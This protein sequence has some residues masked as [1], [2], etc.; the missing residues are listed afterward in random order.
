MTA[1]AAHPGYGHTAIGLS[2]LALLCI[3]TLT[4]I[5][6]DIRR[7]VGIAVI[8]AAAQLAIVALLV[9]A[10]FA[11]PYLIALL[12]AVMLTTATL[13]TGGRLRGL[14]GARVAVLGAAVIGAVSVVGICFAVPVVPREARYVVALGGITLGGTMIA[15][16]LAG[17]AF[18]L[19]TRTRHDEIEAWLSVGATPR[20][21]CSSLCRQSIRDALLPVLDQTRTVGL[22]SLPGAFVGALAGGASAA[23]AARFQLIVLVAL[24]TAETVSAAV[25]LYVLGA[26]KTIPA[27]ETTGAAG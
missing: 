16:T 3:V 23:E 4:L 24:L 11:S 19:A 1:A 17:R 18:L 13:T 22:V 2:L 10:I 25:L 27:A 7:S 14:P 6:V 5:H 9:R 20:Q 12:L 8:R 15:C 21:A 26:P